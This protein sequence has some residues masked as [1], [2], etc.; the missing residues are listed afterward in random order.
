[1]RHLLVIG[2]FAAAIAFP[3]TARADDAIIVK[4]V[5]GLD[6]AER[7]AVRAD[8]D[9]TLDETL[10]LANT[11]VVV[12][13]PGALDEALD[14]LNANPDVVYAEP[15]LPVSPASADPQFANEWGLQQHRPD[16]LD[17]RDAGRRHRRAGGVG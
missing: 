12:A 14:A 4:R 3:A 11:E 10:T 17:R 1:M 13:E 6:R 15:D 8:A 7:A 5:P 2:T 16:G 9:V